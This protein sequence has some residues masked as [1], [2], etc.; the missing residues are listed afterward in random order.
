MNDIKL[1]TNQV[2]ESKSCMIKVIHSGQIEL[3]Q[4]PKFGKVSLTFHEGKLK[5]VEESKQTRYN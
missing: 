2:E 4:P 3:I 1:T 5:A